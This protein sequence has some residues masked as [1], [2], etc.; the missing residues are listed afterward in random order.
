[1]PAL[2]IISSVASTVMSTVVATVALVFS[3]RQ[4][5]GWR[6]VVLATDSSLSSTSGSHLFKFSVTIEFWNRRKYPVALRSSRTKVTGL[7]IFD[8][9]SGVK[10]DKFVENN[11]VYQE[12]GAIVEPSASHRFVIEVLFGEQCMDAM[13]PLFDVTLEVFDPHRNRR[14]ELKISH[15][16]FYP[17]LGWKKS[18]GERRAAAEAYEIG[19]SRNAFEDV[20]DM[21][22]QADNDQKNQV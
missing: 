13:R 8:E 2:E 22:Q 10:D 21:I 12:F 9:N 14:R 17:D 11:I 5:V 20:L 18:E 16:I 3:Y 19:K 1:M 7:D 15:K 6:P 4:N